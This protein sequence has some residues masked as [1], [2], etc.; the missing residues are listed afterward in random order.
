M[1]NDPPAES[2]SKNPPPRAARL[3]RTA[4]AVVVVAWLGFGFGYLWPQAYPETS[5]FSVWAGWAAFMV[6]DIGSKA[7]EVHTC[8]I[9]GVTSRAGVNPNGRRL[10]S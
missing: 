6:R 5:T 7:R 2:V 1:S 8:T 3:Q 10:R 9:P 4:W